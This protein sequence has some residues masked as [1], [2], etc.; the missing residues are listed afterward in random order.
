MSSPE[1][2]LDT[3]GA[4]GPDALLG[5]PEALSLPTNWEMPIPF[6]GE[7][8][9]VFPVKALPPACRNFVA[10][11]AASTQTPEDLA[12]MLSLSALATATAGRV[13][14]ELRRGWREPLALWTLTVLPPASRKSAVLSAVARP[15]YEIEREQ[16]TA[17]RGRIAEARA[18][19][20]VAEQ[21]SRNAVARAAKA[22]RQ[23]RA[24]RD[25]EAVAER[26]ALE[27]LP[28]P[29]PPQLLAGDVTP[30]RAAGILAEQGGRLGI[31]SA[32]G[33]LFG[34]LAGRYNQGQV[35]LDTFLAG[36]SGDTVR[37][38]RQGSSFTIDRPALSLGLAVQPD[39]LRELAERREMRGRGLLARFLYAM[40][41]SG[42]GRRRQDAPPVPPGEAATWAALLQRLHRLPAPSPAEP[43]PLLRLDASARDLHTTFCAA[44][45]P[46][47][48][49]ESGDLANAG[50]AD[51]AG[52]LAGAAGRL[53]GLL[54]LAST[55]SC[56]GQEGEFAPVPAAT[57]QGALELADY[58]LAH[59][60]AA[61]AALGARQDQ[62]PARRMLAALSRRARLEFSERDAFRSVSGQ[63]PFSG[64]VPVHEALLVLEEYGWT[65]RI[66]EQARPGRAGRPPSP[67][68][69][70]HPRALAGQ[71]RQNRVLSF[72]SGSEPS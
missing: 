32:E 12:G 16:L 64:M 49:P 3:A 71:N 57:M 5:D 19:R 60:L 34:T 15:L 69:E 28:F 51:W 38:D 27:R 30:E 4:P 14:V 61:F 41:E 68:W 31:L 1:G 8:L 24:E 46:R 39:V 42:V 20:E 26:H 53:A 25:A 63:A 35:N 17:L 40:P 70:L 23:D 13:E 47:L 11:L 62:D 18:M 65:R 59:A 72:V 37:V 50:A 48:H 52:K 36:H 66:T 2:R 67:R 43:M 29:V 45:E 54:H 21:R 56:Q 22:P 44:L 6:G 10:S 7:V 55:Y 9:P 58:C 33:G